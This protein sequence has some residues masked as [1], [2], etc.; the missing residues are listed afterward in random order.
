MATGGRSR[1]IPNLPMDGNKVIGYREAMTLSVQPKKMVIVGSGAIGIEFAYFYNSI[2]TEVTIVEYLKNIL[3]VEDT[4]ISSTLARSFRKRGVKIMTQAE[5][6]KV[7]KK[8]EGCKV[9]VSTKKGEEI[10]ECDIVLSAVGL[11]TNLEDLGIESQGI[12]TEKGKVMVDEYYA[13]NISGIYAIG[14]IV[15]GQTLAHVASAEGIIC[16]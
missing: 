2:G 12:M 9:S 6:T 3:P 11:T 8:G 10:L 7:D 13:T 1:E 14:D 5:V 16:V 15:Q 4:D